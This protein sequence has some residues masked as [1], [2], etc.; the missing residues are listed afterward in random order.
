MT[1]ARVLSAPL[2]NVSMS[3]LPQCLLTHEYMSILMSTTTQPTG[4]SILEVSSTFAAELGVVALLDCCEGRLELRLV[5]A[6][7]DEH[8]EVV[9]VHVG[10][11]EQ[12]L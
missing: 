8:A 11:R 5:S 3:I 2:L 12:A 1:M 9:R 4:S 10:V 6:H 7:H